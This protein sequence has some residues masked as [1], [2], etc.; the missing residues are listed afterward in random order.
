MDRLLISRNPNEVD[1]SSFHNANSLGFKLPIETKEDFIKLDLELGENGQLKSHIWL[2]LSLI[3]GTNV[4]DIVR[5][6]LRELMA[7]RLQMQYEAAKPAKDKT[8]FKQHNTLYLFVIE[9]VRSCCAREKLSLPTEKEI[10]KFASLFFTNS[11][12]EDGGVQERKKRIALKP[13][14]VVKYLK[15]VEDGALRGYV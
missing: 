5:T 7:R 3:G 9:L 10:L 13:A 15:E 6:I 14:A 1:S 8:V 11:A 2:A 12:D 4:K